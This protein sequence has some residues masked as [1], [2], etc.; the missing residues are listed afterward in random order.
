[1]EVGA[2]HHSLCF[3]SNIGIGFCPGCGLGHSIAYLFRGDFIASFDAHPLGVP[4]VILLVYRIIKVLFF[5]KDYQ[6]LKT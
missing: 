5:Q 6:F 2:G 1:M 3:F 4:V